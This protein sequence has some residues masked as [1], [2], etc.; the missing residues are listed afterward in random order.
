MTSLRPIWIIDI[1]SNSFLVAVSIYL[2]V[3]S[4][5]I[6]TMR[7]HVLLWMYLYWQV[8][9]LTIFIF[10]HSIPHIIGRIM[11]FWGLGNTWKAIEPFT[12]SI[13][14]LTFVVVAILTFLYRDLEHAS[15]RYGTL[16][17]TKKE[18]EQSIIMLKES[19][20]KIERDAVEIFQKNRELSALYKIATEIGK[21]L[22]L[23]KVMS[24]TIREVK[25]LVKADFL[26]VY[27]VK[28]D[29]IVLQV[30]EG[31]TGSL[32][33][34]AAVRSAGEPWVKRE[35]LQGRAFFV[36]ESVSEKT[37]KIDED[38][39]KGGLQA[40]T[41]IP[42]M[43]KGKVVGVLSVGSISLDG[44]DQRQINTLMTIGNYIGIVIENSMLYEELKQKV[45]DLE[46][47]SRF[48]VGREMRILEIKE[49]LKNL[50]ESCPDALSKNEKDEA[51]KFP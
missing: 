39:K 13:N 34:K 7:P 37:G 38:F 1:I 44:I 43:A 22:E 10:S 36:Q 21:S 2:L 11:Q 49:K 20:E 16:S 51:K 46:R 25:D 40:W 27:L 15:E 18:L 33:D 4:R 31:L 19:S 45:D 3:E 24:A 47:F 29:K 28:G 26:A 50:M 9:A 5:R 6:R 32:L 8:L 30:S 12:G 23:D 42:V 35:I 14:T 48:S 17:E 41:A